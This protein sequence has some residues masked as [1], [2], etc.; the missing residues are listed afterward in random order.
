VK[1]LEF[2]FFSTE[3]NIDKKFEHGGWSRIYEYP[4]VLECID[5]Y[6]KSK[7]PKIHNTCW[8]WAGVHVTFKNELEQRYGMSNIKNSDIKYSEFENTSIYNIKEKPTEDE[9][10]KYDVVLNISTIE[11]VNNFSH[12]EIFNNLYKQVKQDGILIITFDYPGLNLDD[13]ENH[14]GLKIKDDKQRVNGSN[15]VAENKKYSHLNFGLICVQKN[16][17]LNKLPIKM[18]I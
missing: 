4:A 15:S 8:G 2:K 14:L 11:E 6:C 18:I 13:I 12:V 9:V 5:K 3:D 1:I 16:D 17:I 10:G 7:E